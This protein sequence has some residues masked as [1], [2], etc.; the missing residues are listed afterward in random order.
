MYGPRPLRPAITI[1]P[2][3]MAQPPSVTSLPRLS[4][5]ATPLPRLHSLHPPTAPL[6][7][8]HTI[9]APMTRL[10]YSQVS[11]GANTTNQVLKTEVTEEPIDEMSAA[12]E[13]KLAAEVQKARDE[14]RRSVEQT[15]ANNVQFMIHRAMAD[16]RSEG[17]AEMQAKLDEAEGRVEELRKALDPAKVKAAYDRGVRDGG[18]NG[19]NKYSLNPETKPSDDR[20]AFEQILQERD[21]TIECQ[22]RE[23][24][25]RQ[26]RIEC[27]ERQA[28][29]PNAQH[30][31]PQQGQHLSNE[32]IQNAQNE[33]HVQLQELVNFKRQNEQM[34]AD[35]N[36]WQVQWGLIKT[37]LVKWQ[38]ECNL[39]AEQLSACQRQL[40]HSTSELGQATRELKESQEEGERKTGKL[41]HFQNQLKQKAEELGN[42]QLQLEQQSAEL[43]K[44]GT[45]AIE[46]AG[47]FKRQEA[48]IHRLNLRLE[49]VQIQK[50]QS[51]S[52]PKPI[53]DEAER[54]QADTLKED[55]ARTEAQL[56]AAQMEIV[57]L[58]EKHIKILQSCSAM[59]RQS[60]ETKTSHY[61]STA[62]NSELEAEVN[63]LTSKLHEIKTQLEQ[64]DVALATASGEY[65]K[66]Q[67]THEDVV[68]SCQ[69]IASDLDSKQ[70]EL[71][72][73]IGKTADLRA[74]E[75]K[76]DGL[77]SLIEGLERQKSSLLVDMP[78]D[79]LFTMAGNRGWRT[80]QRRAGMQRPAR[81]RPS[82]ATLEENRGSKK[83]DSKEA[84]SEEEAMFR[85]L[86]IPL[87]DGK[88]ILENLKK[89]ER[90]S[91]EAP[92]IIAAQ[93]TG[94]PLQII[95]K[96]TGTMRFRPD[97]PNSMQLIVA[98]LL[99]LPEDITNKICTNRE[100]TIA[101]F[102]KPPQGPINMTNKRFT[103]GGQK[104]AESPS[105]KRG[106]FNQERLWVAFC[107]L[108]GLLGLYASYRQANL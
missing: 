35:L 42:C 65:S 38:D 59:K 101:A 29:F 25:E 56:T 72:R 53:I 98:A 46:Q 106:R 95:K 7:G 97:H 2:T 6:P 90:P 58:R 12:W 28:N 43:E 36:N 66:L 34:R 49:G 99:E 76:V 100:G 108:I 107:T 19:Y 30:P 48:E 93:L 63:R 37:D 91:R 41:S 94:A 81:E 102:A 10:S 79:A 45:L 71:N 82:A 13:R 20:L 86:H 57:V 5:S 74:L 11:E 52:P 21:K 50:R 85:F 51:S 84:I 77:N 24:N 9:T 3:K 103:C 92:A 27:L 104:A 4:A 75:R 69:Q 14:T 44:A 68:A 61:I 33:F 39:K 70:N 62:K 96:I 40:G 88:A 80:T 23:L 55:L 1:S 15:L 22:Q 32:Q 73:V 8:F 26:H 105:A 83:D 31:S 89:S 78:E 54:S 18:I 87:A 16:G 64:K 47:A 60:R 17:K 67:K